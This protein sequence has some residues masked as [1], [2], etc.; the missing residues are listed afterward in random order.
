[1]ALTLPSA[2]HQQRPCQ[3]LARWT[4][5]ARSTTSSWNEA[6]QNSPEAA[7]EAAKQFESLFMRE[8]IKSMR[9]ATMKSACWTVPRA[10]WAPTCWTSNCRCR[11]R[12]Q[13]GA[14]RK[15]LRASSR[16]RWVW[17]SP[18]SRCLPR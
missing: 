1:M 4:M 12:A 18:P 5:H 6:G 7:K 17:Q 15:P 9:E 13:P 2:T 14:C 10:T 8:L 11:C 3:A 16:A